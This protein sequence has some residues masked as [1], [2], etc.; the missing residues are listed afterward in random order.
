MKTESHPNKWL[1]ALDMVGMV[2]APL[3]ISLPLF[4]WAI[5]DYQ[6]VSSNDTN[7]KAAIL[8]FL[9]AFGLFISFGYMFGWALKHY[10]SHQV[11]RDEL[12]V[13]RTIY[14]GIILTGLILYF[15]FIF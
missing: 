6:A 5:L 4:L 1:R 7:H 2:I 3:S 14:I 12:I 15:V 9:A 11:T 8:L 10:V 13:F